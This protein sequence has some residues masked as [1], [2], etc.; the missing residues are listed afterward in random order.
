MSKIYTLYGNN[1]DQAIDLLGLKWLFF[2]R[3]I[4]PQPFT[5][6]QDIN[7]DIRRGERIGIIGRNGAGKTTL[8]KLITGT[9]QTTAG[10]LS[11]AGDINALMQVGIGFHPEFTG[12]QNIRASLLYSPLSTQERLVAEAEIINFV[13]LGDFL[14]QP[15]KTYS[16]GMKARLQFACATSIKP[17]ILVIDEIL[18]AGDA[19]F[20]AKSAARMDKLTGSGC[21]LLLVSHS[22]GQVLQF[23]DRAI[24]LEDGR[25]QDD[26][27]ARAVVKRYEKFTYELSKRAKLTDVEKLSSVHSSN[28]L[29]DRT[30]E[31]LAT[32][33]PGGDGGDPSNR[34]DVEDSPI[35][36]EHTSLHDQ[37][38]EEA[39][40]FQAGKGLSVRMTIKANRTGHFPCCFAIVIFA[41]D[42]RMLGR[43][44]S[45]WHKFDLEEGKTRTIEFAYDPLMLG[46]GHYF[47]SCAVY[48]RLDLRNLSDAKWYDLYSRAFEFDVAPD[49]NDP[50]PQFHHP[51]QWSL[52][53]IEKNELAQKEPKES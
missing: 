38:G 39:S 14:D 28:W 11:V 1:A 32:S 50:I 13:E 25:I 26:G 44:C 5:A 16:L 37:E 36:I 15:L 47:F 49:E 40:Y 35:R 42:G 10:E 3:C 8:L 34:W 41:A 23:C 12:I 30:R 48:E 53:E 4:D 7:L 24:W 31:A 19:Y 2:W 33:M 45:D 27:E 52:I 20:S 18:G 9:S 21:T 22:M 29:R 17:D 6:L 51:C 46:S 43:H